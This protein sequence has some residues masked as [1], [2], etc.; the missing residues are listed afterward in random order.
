MPGDTTALTDVEAQLPSGTSKRV[1]EEGKLSEIEARETDFQSVAE[2]VKK[3]EQMG[4]SGGACEQILIVLSWVIVMIIPIFWFFI[5]RTVTDYERALIFRLG[6]VQGGIRG[7]GL[8]VINP[9]LDVIKVVDQRIETVNLVPQDMMTK[10]SVTIS[11]DGIVYT[12]VVNPQR[13]VLEINNYRYA[14]KMFSAT[15][16][17]AVVGSVDLETMLTK[18]NELNERLRNIIEKECKI[19][20][21]TVPAVE[22]KDVIL[23]PNMQRAMAAEAETERERRAK[24]ISSLG[25]V[26]AADNLAKAALT[27]AQAP[28]ALQLRYLHTLKN[29]SVE[30]NS[31]IIF[32]LPMELMKGFVKNKS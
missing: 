15:S 13:A 12:K 19:W 10:D 31:T 21:V 8:F 6:K 24:K 32:P 7:P 9:I 22:I 1:A 30:K 14:S 29:I 25:E 5:F 2:M 11:V 4:T 3:R 26:E 18:R 20:G 16:L 28:G 23:P 17:R 27:I